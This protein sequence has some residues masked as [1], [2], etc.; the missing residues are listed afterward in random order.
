MKYEINIW[1]KIA[2]GIIKLEIKLNCKY[3]WGLK[4][5][6]WIFLQNEKNDAKAF[7]SVLDMLWCVIFFCEI[8]VPMIFQTSIKTFNMK[9]KSI[10]L[11]V[12]FHLATKKFYLKFMT[13]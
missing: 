2:E 8:F 12:Y 7:S 11:Y 9:W 13:C 3:I 5:I 6:E 10:N 4:E 1:W